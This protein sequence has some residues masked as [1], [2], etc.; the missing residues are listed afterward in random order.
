M[1]GDLLKEI[2]DEDERFEAAKRN[3]LSILTKGLHLGG[4]ITWKRDNL[5]EREN[6]R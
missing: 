5:Y 1:M 4:R 6:L 3:A 2:V